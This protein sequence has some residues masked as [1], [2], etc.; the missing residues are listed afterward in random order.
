MIQY[1]GKSKCLNMIW[2]FP[3]AHGKRN[4]PILYMDNSIS[5]GWGN[6]TAN[7]YA[8]NSGKRR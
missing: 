7:F 2:P 3:P 1:K 6:D 5:R 4:I 8:E